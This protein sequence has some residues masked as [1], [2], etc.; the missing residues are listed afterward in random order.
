MHR[1]RINKKNINYWSLWPNQY[2]W[3]TS[4]TFNIYLTCKIL[5]ILLLA[6]NLHLNK[7]SVEYIKHVTN[8]NPIFFC[9]YKKYSCNRVFVNLQRTAHQYFSQLTLSNSAGSFYATLIKVIV[10][11]ERGHE[12]RNQKTEDVG[13]PV[14]NFLRLMWEVSSVLCLVV[15]LGE[16]ISFSNCFTK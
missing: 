3:S 7:L 15:F 13:K 11:W 4:R 8:Y 2:K 1:V 6:L 5:L 10:I 14:W 12:L 9:L 16:L